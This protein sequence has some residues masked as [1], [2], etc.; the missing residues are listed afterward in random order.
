[1]DNMS[2]IDLAYNPE[3]HAR[4]KHIDRRH[5]FIRERDESL[6]ITVPFILSAANVA[7]FFTKLLPPRRFFLYATRSRTLVASLLNI[8]CA[9]GILTLL[10]IVCIVFFTP[11]ALRNRT[12]ARAPA[13]R[14]QA[15][16]RRSARP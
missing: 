4:T 14:Q 8:A 6:G 1:M 2:A 11:S 3:H 10:A 15:A 16:P 9:G 13:Q 7:N 5:F 12:H